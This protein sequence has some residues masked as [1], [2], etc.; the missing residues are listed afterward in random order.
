[1]RE[2]TSLP[3]LL[4]EPIVRAALVEDLG[5]AG[6]ITT[7]A[8]VP[9]EARFSGAMVAR[10]PGTIAGTEAAR[11]AF[12]LVDPTLDVSILQP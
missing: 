2:I 12:D 7:A 6:D 10:R 1:M 4:V 9:K 11:I 3:T 5:R 8:V